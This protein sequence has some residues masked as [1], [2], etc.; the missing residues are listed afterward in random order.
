[1]S[2]NIFATVNFNLT[3]PRALG[4]NKSEDYIPLVPTATSTGGL[5]YI[6]SKGFNGSYT[7]RYIKSRPAN[8]DNR[9]V[10]KGYFLLDASVNYTRPK[11]EI[12]LAIE[13]MLNVK[14]NEAQFAITSRLADDPTPITELNFTPGT[15]FFARVK[16]ALF[17]LQF[18][19]AFKKEFF[20]QTRH[21]NKKVPVFSGTFL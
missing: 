8:E 3:R 9:I 19:D 14:L 10:A 16:L 15:P 18:D 20:E 11:Y 2:K 21:E 7:Y 5:Y 17:F 13:N 6:A 12:G 1:M 4:V